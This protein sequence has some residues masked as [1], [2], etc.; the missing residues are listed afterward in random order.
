MK[1]FKELG[2]NKSFIKGLTELNIINPTEI[3]EQVIP[4]LLNYNTDL[5]GQAQNSCFWPSFVTKNGCF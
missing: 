5:V 2:V 4:M 1:T 3:Q